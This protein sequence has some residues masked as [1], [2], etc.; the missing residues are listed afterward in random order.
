VINYK[1]VAKGTA[2][3]VWH[4]VWKG[5]FHVPTPSMLFLAGHRSKI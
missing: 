1:A 2:N 3:S 5:I 4:K